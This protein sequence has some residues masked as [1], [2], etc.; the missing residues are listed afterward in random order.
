MGMPGMPP[1]L[2][3]GDQAQIQM[4]QQM[5]QMMQMQMQWMQQVQ[6][7]V[8][9]QGNPNPGTPQQV[10]QQN[11]VRSSMYGPPPQIPRPQSVQGQNPPPFQAGQRTMSTLN[12]SMAPW[13]NGQSFLPS[14]NVNGNYAPSIAPSE[15]SN[16]GLA[17]RYRPV[18]VAPEPDVASARRAS[19][20]TTSSFRPW[21]QIDNGPRGPVHAAKPSVNTL[22]RR[23]PLATN[24]DDDD[25]RGWAEMKLKKDKKQRSWALRKGQNDLQE[26]YTS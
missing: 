19:T 8:T 23:S 2:T 12:P 14:I 11:S 7:M 5:T 13:N 9:G 24:D 10:G 15:R 4:S 21:S 3:P 6:Q 22:G 18:S 17:S 25:E 16:V 20:F 26:L 1:M